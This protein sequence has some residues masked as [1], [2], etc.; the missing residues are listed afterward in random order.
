[1]EAKVILEAKSLKK[2]YQRGSEI[3]RALDG[4]DFKIMEREIV[5]IVGPSGSGKT[6]LMNLI[7]CLDKVTTGSLKIGNTDVTSF[8]ENDLIKIRRENVG[9]VFQRFYLI[10]T[11]TVRENIELPLIFAK[12]SINEKKLSVLLKE[13]G[14]IGKERIQIKYLSGGDKQRTGIARALVNDP[15][16]LV[17]DE[18]T[19]KLETEVRGQILELFKSLSEKGLA[20]VIATHD[21]EL[22]QATQRIIHLQDG[23]IVPKEKS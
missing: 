3:V 6:T 4:V 8:E 5:S 17:A 14:L 10:P 22:A 9:F 15:K 1:M 21:L 11:L 2:Y 18:P 20:I 12:K 19:G 16:I 7:S 23:K 13:V